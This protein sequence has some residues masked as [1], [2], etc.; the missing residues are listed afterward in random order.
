MHAVECYS[1]LKRTADS[2]HPKLHWPRYCWN[3]RQSAVDQTLCMSIANQCLPGKR[4][5][6]RDKKHGLSRFQCWRFL[7]VQALL[8]CK[9]CFVTSRS[10]RRRT[11]SSSWPSRCD[12]R[13]TGMIRKYTCNNHH[14]KAKNAKEYKH[15]KCICDVPC[16]DN[17]ANLKHTSESSSVPGLLSLS[18][19]SGQS[20]KKQGTPGSLQSNHQLR[21]K[22]LNELI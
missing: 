21:Q 11:R 5:T 15:L 20:A 18:A 13:S 16:L 10:F 22:V 4:P 9:R 3:G 19:R 6:F 17:K 7:L 14:A 1:T 12:V 2:A 8:A